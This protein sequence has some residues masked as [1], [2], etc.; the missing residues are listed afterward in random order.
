M[1]EAALAALTGLLIGSFLNVCIY[2]LPRDLSVVQP[3]RSFCPAC[4]AQIA[5]YDN[6]P[7]LSWL[8]LRGRCRSCKAPIHWRYPVVELLTGILFAVGVLQ[9]GATLYAV[10]LC[11]FAAIL[12]VLVITDLETRILPDEFTLGGTLAGVALAWLVPLPA[13]LFGLMLPPGLDGR[14]V[15]VIEAA[16]AAALL[17]GLLWAVGATY[18]LIRHREGM[19]LG[20]VKMIACIGAFLGLEGTLMTLLAGSLLGSVSGLLYIAIMRKNAASY[21]LPFGTFLGIAALFT[22]LV[23][24]LH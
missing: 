1:L 5:W 18:K 8:L 21:E 19:G 2:R 24:V 7:L 14:M 13:S 15:S 12:V 3:S 4:A 23:G 11:I 9:F 17:A 10:R 22:A 20:D 6:V 16:L